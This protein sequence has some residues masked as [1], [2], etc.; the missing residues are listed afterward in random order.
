[1]QKTMFAEGGY[2]E[3]NENLLSIRHLKD[4]QVEICLGKWK[5][6]VSS[7]EKGLG[8]ERD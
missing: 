8:I 1:M 2:E 4:K 6:W 5:M 7:S 3:T